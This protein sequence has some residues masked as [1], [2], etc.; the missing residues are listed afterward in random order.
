MLNLNKTRILASKEFA[1]ATG[2]TINAEGIALMQVMEN[3]VEKC[4]PASGTS[5]TFVGFSY[6][7]VFTEAV[8]SEVKEYKLDSS[9]IHVIELAH[10]PITGQINVYDTVAGSSL[11]SGDPSSSPGTFA[12]SGRNLTVNVADPTLL[13]VTMRFSPSLVEAFYDG[14]IA[15]TPLSATDVIGSIGVIQAGEVYTNM[16]DASIDWRSVS[17]VKAKDGLLSNTGIDTNCKIIEIPSVDSPYLGV[18]FSTL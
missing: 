3:G 13:V 6:A 17:S 5:G 16:F 15:S 9:G 4:A 18:R 11:S 12:I 1:V 10:E 2:V 8:R 7:Q 14:G